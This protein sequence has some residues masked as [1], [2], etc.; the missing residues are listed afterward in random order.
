MWMLL[1]PLSMSKLRFRI[2]RWSIRTVGRMVSF[3]FREF[4]DFGCWFS[5]DA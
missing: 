5:I 1:L 2:S 4:F 3:S